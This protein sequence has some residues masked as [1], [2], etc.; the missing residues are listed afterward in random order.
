MSI[1]KREQ[2]QG[3]DNLD[4]L[5]LVAA[6][7][8]KLGFIAMIDERLP[9]DKNKGAKTTMGQRV[10]AMVLNGLGFIDDRLYMFPK[11]LANKP[12]EQ[13]LGSGI[14]AA[15]FNDD[16]LGRC[17]DKIYEYG[18][19][20][21]FSELALSIGIKHKMLG[22]KTKIDTT[23]LT[24]YGE[25]EEEDETSVRIDSKSNVD[26]EV[27][28]NKAERSVLEYPDK[29]VPKRGYAK[30]HRHDLKQMTLLL[31]TTGKSGFPIWMESQN[32][33]ASDQKTMQ[34]AAQRIQKLCNALKLAPAF[35]HVGDSAMYLSCVKH[36]E[37]L[38]WLSRVP[39][40][41]TQA[42]ELIKRTDIP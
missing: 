9:V 4:H 30:N 20:K 41:I 25:Y 17:L 24:V 27:K 40:S 39:E 31:A 12:V 35:L 42:K 16:A 21:M 6:T 22:R 7:I 3:S 36:G 38:L 28:E 2:I 11:F 37:N 26:P 1:I 10:A 14:T 15:D 19:T 29:A 5:G 32:G 18:T 34:E 8:D 33:N 13:L 23:T